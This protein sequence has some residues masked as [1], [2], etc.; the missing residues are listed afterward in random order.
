MLY[1]SERAHS[2]SSIANGSG[3]YTLRVYFIFNV[4]LSINLEKIF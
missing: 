1:L 4:L 3:K 2:V